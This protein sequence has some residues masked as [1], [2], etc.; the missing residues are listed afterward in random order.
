MSSSVGSSW[1]YCL[2]GHPE[3]FIIERQESCRLPIWAIKTFLWPKQVENVFVSTS[4]GFIYTLIKAIFF[5]FTFVVCINT[6][7]WCNEARYDQLH[8]PSPKWLVLGEEGK[9]SINIYL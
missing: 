7:D 5:D 6:F 3:A 1:S 8:W 9:E 4:N 2:L